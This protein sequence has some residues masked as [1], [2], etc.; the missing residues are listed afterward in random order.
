[1][2]KLDWRIVAMA[3]VVVLVFGGGYSMGSSGRSTLETQLA[4]TKQLQEDMNRQVA[5]VRFAAD[6]QKQEL[7]SVKKKIETIRI[8]DD[9]TIADL[10]S[11]GFE[12]PTE[13]MD[14]LRNHPEMIPVKAVLGGTM[15]FT[16]IRIVNGQWIYA[17]YEDG[18]IAGSSIFAFRHRLDGTIQWDN[19][20]S[21]K[22]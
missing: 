21:E 6:R 11:E 7:E 5:A 13:L 12:N 14:D 19:I 4:K 9:R 1:V 2:R 18:H 20:A 22:E 17:E 16:A 10:K 8:P 3:L 15:A